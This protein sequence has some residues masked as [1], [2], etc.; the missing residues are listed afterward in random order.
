[1]LVLYFPS[2]LIFLH[3]YI[4]HSYTQV[5]STHTHSM[6]LRTAFH[7]T[8][9]NTY[10]KHTKSLSTNESISIKYEIFNT[11]NSKHSKYCNNRCFRICLKNYM[12]FFS[13]IKRNVKLR[14]L[15]DKED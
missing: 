15:K 8:P 6:I 11:R 2:L 9:F 7:K 12:T 3:K 4:F 1:M 14:S 5:N 10:N 13:V